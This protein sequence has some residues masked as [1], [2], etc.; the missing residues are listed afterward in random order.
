MHRAKQHGY[1]LTIDLEQKTVRDD[2]GF[3]ATFAI[4]D[5]SRH[6]LLNGLDDI[7]L[8]LQQEADIEA[9]EKNHPVSAVM[10][11]AFRV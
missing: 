7:G 11:S 10:Q 8:T 9:Y 4:D 6:C 5:F 1:Q 3:S 2:Q